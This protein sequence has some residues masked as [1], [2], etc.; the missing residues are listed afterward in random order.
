[1][2]I[3]Y[4]GIGCKMSGYHTID[5]FLNIMKKEFTHK[6]WKHELTIFS[7]ETHYQLQ[8][9]NWVLPDDFIFFSLDDWLE[10][11]GAELVKDIIEL[12]K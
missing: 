3:Y 10:Y 11:S 7:R 6:D 4:T 2:K 1:M 8:F 9:K 5:E 12:T